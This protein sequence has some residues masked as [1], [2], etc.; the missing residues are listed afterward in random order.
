MTLRKLRKAKPYPATVVQKR[1]SSPQWL[2]G[3]VEEW[4]K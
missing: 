2:T 1:R 4:W 3:C